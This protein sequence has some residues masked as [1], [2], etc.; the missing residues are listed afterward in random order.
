M[1]QLRCPYFREHARGQDLRPLIFCDH[2]HSPVPRPAAEKKRDP[3][4]LLC[5]G[6]LDRCPIRKTEWFDV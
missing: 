3:A 2:K 5:E 1:A 6:D 4:V